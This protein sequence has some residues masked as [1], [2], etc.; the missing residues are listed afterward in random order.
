MADYESYIDTRSPKEKQSDKSGALMLLAGVAG[1]LVAR[2][3]LAITRGVAKDIIGSGLGSESRYAKYLP[4]KNTSSKSR[5]IR[6]AT[7]DT[8]KQLKDGLTDPIGY[9]SNKIGNIAKND[10]LRPLPS[11]AESYNI[12]VGYLNKNL[13]HPSQ[14]FPAW[15]SFGLKESSLFDKIIHGPK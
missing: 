11:D 8:A 6:E 2:R 12:A 1:F 3:K 5:S 15:E 10:L 9:V 14:V 4:S 7:I 13:K